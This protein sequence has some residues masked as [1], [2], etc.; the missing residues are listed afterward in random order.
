MSNK[1]ENSIDTQRLLNAFK[2]LRREDLQKSVKTAIARK[3]FEN[4]RKERQIMIKLPRQIS[5]SLSTQ[6]V[7]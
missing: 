7:K 4:N 5:S 3:K 1:K 6:I 2:N